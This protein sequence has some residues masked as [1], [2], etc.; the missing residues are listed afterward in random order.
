[1]PVKDI[2]INIGLD[3][4]IKVDVGLETPVSIKFKD[5]IEVVRERSSNYIHTQSIASTIWTINHPL[6]KFPSVTII[7]S[8]D[9]VVYGDI[10]YMSTSQVKITFSAAFGGKAYLN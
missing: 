8:G 10:Q 9:N 4:P 7:D 5:T 2:K 6:Q 1:M 3:Q